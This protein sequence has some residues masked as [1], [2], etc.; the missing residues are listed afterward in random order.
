MR[1]PAFITGKPAVSDRNPSPR[2]GT[3]QADFYRPGSLGHK[4]RAGVLDPAAG[5]SLHFPA[6]RPPDRLEQ[7]VKSGFDTEIHLPEEPSRDLQK[8]AATLPKLG[9]E[10]EQN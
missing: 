2:R 7:G 8:A 6:G 4:D 1:K 5:I 3:E 10:R 9:E